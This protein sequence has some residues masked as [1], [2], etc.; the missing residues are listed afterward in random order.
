MRSRR[1]L[2]ALIALAALPALAQKAD[3][4]W[5][6]AYLSAGPRTADGSPP[7]ALRAALRAIGYVEG[8]NIAYESRFAEADAERLPALAAELVRS[9]PDVIVVNGAPAALAAKQATSVVPVVIGFP[10]GDAVAMGLIAS[11][12]RPGG[13]VT[14]HTDEVAPLSAKRIEL[15]KDVLPTASRISVVWNA[16]DDAMTLRYRGIEHAAKA[17]HIEVQ[18]V[19]VRAAGDFDTAISL[20]SRNHPDAILMVSDALTN[21]HRKRI[22]DFASAQRIPAMYEIATY[23]SDGGLMAYGPGIEETWAT[24]AGYVDRIFKGSK[25]SD[26]PA[27]YPMRYYLT[28]S[29]KSADSLGMTIPQS[30]LLRADN[31]LQ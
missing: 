11:V 6:A 17:L 19:Q 4:V 22:I 29:R 30:I 26:L 8:V 14:G 18:P 2:L 21:M 3:R 24:T 13:N 12:A 20:M 16:T 23:V 31:V 1:V 10:S 15:L 25:A 9:K 5:H 28:I 27:A 7:P